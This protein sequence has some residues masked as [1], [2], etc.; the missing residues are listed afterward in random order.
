MNVPMF[1]GAILRSGN[2]DA[3]SPFLCN[4]WQRLIDVNS[5]VKGEG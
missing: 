1:K 3:G 2:A 4:F 5:Y